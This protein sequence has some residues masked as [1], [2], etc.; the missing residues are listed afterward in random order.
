[1]NA[2]NPPAIPDTFKEVSKEEFFAFLNGL[3]VHPSTSNPAFTLWETRN[4]VAIGW[5]LPGWRSPSNT[6]HKYALRAAQAAA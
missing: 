1:M 3:D 4:R 2:H 6:P 5:S